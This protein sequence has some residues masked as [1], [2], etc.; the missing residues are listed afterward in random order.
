MPVGLK[1]DAA[2][3]PAIVRKQNGRGTRKHYGHMCTTVK[4]R[5]GNRPGQ[6]RPWRRL[7]TCQRQLQLGAKV[8]YLF[9]LR[10]EHLA[11]GQAGSIQ[12]IRGD[13]R[14]GGGAALHVGLK[15]HFRAS[16]ICGNPT[17]GFRPTRSC[18]QSRR[19]SSR[20][21]LNTPSLCFSMLYDAT[22]SLAVRRNAEVFDPETWR[23]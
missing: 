6:S 20:W 11:H 18:S 22:T 8:F 21:S 23:I 15:R 14:V 13:H 16:T 5:L 10:G 4:W 2:G 9:L 3:L 19:R 17:A 12:A 1:T 7:A